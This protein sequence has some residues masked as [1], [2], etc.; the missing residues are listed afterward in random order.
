MH[1]LERF[2]PLWLAAFVVAVAGESIAVA[3]A[4]GWY[5][6]QP[7]LVEKGVTEQQMS[8]K[9]L[10]WSDFD[11]A[12]QRDLIAAASLNF[13]VPLGGWVHKGSFDTADACERTRQKLIDL[14]KARE[15]E[16]LRKV[17]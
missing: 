15:A 4:T 6:L 9:F 14:A 16:I 1:H 11:K 12:T 13:S 8:M 2:L 5:L 7:P 17:S 10:H 3:A